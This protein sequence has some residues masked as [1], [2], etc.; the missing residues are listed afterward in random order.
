MTHIFIGMQTL[1]E[2]IEDTIL[3]HDNRG[4]GR[5]RQALL[6]GYCWR[7]AQ[8]IRDNKGVVLIG[9]GFPVSGSFESDG[10]IGAIALYRVLKELNCE[11]VLVCAPPISKI[12]GRNFRTYELPLVEWEKSKPV[13]IRALRNLKPRLIV[14]IERPGV[15]ADGRYYNMHKND[16]SALT[17][18]FDLFLQESNCPS[19]AFG[20]GGNEIGM[21]NVRDALATLDIIPAV[22]TCDELVIASVSNWGVYGVIAALCRLLNRDLFEIFDSETIANYLVDNGC[23][24]GVTTR[25]ESSEDGFPISVGLGI[26]DQLRDLVFKYGQEAVSD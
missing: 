23:V 5:L 17:A 22:T 18:K 14:S 25:P 20:D 13:V 8:I 2:R 7:A 16:I 24:D 4:M 10:P 1:S 9:T 11:P 12:L 6:P 3:Q 19:I 15:A 26:I 21:G